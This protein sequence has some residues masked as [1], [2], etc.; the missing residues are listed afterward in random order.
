MATPASIPRRTAQTDP[1]VCGAFNGGG[2][3]AGAG[4]ESLTSGRRNCGFPISEVCICADSVEPGSAGGWPGAVGN[5]AGAGI[6]PAGIRTAASEEGK[7]GGDFCDGIT[8]GPVVAGRF[9]F[10]FGSRCPLI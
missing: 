9:G 6:G 7:E 5:S 10:W 1:R 8:I 4:V 2:F 3:G